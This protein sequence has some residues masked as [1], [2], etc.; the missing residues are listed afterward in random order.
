[1]KFRTCNL[2]TA[3]NHGLEGPMKKPSHLSCTGAKRASETEVGSNAM[4]RVLERAVRRDRDK[5]NKIYDQASSRGTGLLPVQYIPETGGHRPENAPGGTGRTEPM[6]TVGQAGSSGKGTHR[7]GDR[8]RQT[9]RRRT[10]NLQPVGEAYPGRRRGGS[11]SKKLSLTTIATTAI[12]TAAPGLLGF[13]IV[14]MALPSRGVSKK[15]GI[16]HSLARSAAVSLNELT[17]GRPLHPAH[18]AGL[19]TP[20]IPTPTGRGEL[21]DILELQ[22]LNSPC[23]DIDAPAS[24]LRSRLGGVGP[25]LANTRMRNGAGRNRNQNLQDRKTRRDGPNANEK[26]P[27]GIFLTPYQ[28]E[29]PGKMSNQG[30]DAQRQTAG[31]VEGLGPTPPK[32]TLRLRRLDRYFEALRRVETGGVRR[33]QLAVG[34]GG[35]SRGPY[36]ISRAYWID[37]CKQLGVNWPYE[38]GVADAARCRA[39]MRGFF[40]RYAPAALATGD[41]QTLARVHNGGPGGMNKPATRSYWRKVRAEMSRPGNNS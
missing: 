8:R 16:A 9:R 38:T 1:M 31:Q 33:P 40:K 4:E 37:G 30:T 35:R 17:R 32:Q 41:W 22:K 15:A 27:A 18:S 5:R 25:R 10:G 21:I 11:E 13:L 24:R 23:V 7:M 3:E 36:Q 29:T 2:P 6:G 34:D 14:G 20:H 39:V 19:E 12:L 28:C 26:I